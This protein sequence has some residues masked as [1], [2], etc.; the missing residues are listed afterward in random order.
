MLLSPFGCEAV[1]HG[2]SG[3]WDPGA[4]WLKISLGL[5]EMSSTPELQ[6]Q[7]SVRHLEVTH[8]TVKVICSSTPTGIT[9]DIQGAHGGTEG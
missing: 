5:C 6:T 4:E 7:K 8:L 9:D 2:T 1:Q 3:F